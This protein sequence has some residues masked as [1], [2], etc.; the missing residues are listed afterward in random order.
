MKIEN[1]VINQ[2][3]NSEFIGD[4]YCGEDKYGDKRRRLQYRNLA[5][6]FINKYKPRSLMNPYN[7]EVLEWHVVVCMDCAFQY[8]KKYGY[9]TTVQGEIIAMAVFLETD[10]VKLLND[11]DLPAFMRGQQGVTPSPVVC[12]AAE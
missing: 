7:R 1:T 12:S 11:P 5:H 9:S 6:F 2:N 10:F 3:D 8:Y 4:L